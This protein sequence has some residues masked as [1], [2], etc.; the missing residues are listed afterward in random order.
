MSVRALQIDEHIMQLLADRA[1]EGLS[2]A[3]S[4]KLDAILVAN[5]AIHRDAM[6][7]AAASVDLAFDTGIVEPL[8]KTLR[9][10]I[11]ADAGGYLATAGAAFRD[12]S[13]GEPSSAVSY[14]QRKARI[15]GRVAWYLLAASLLLAAVGW[16]QVIDIRPAARGFE[17]DYASFV[18]ETLDVI[19]AP[20]AGKVEDLYGVTGDVVWSDQVQAGFMRFTGLPPNDPRRMQYQLWIVDQTRDRNP[21]DGGVFDVVAGDGEV[22]VPIDAKLRV[23]HPAAFALT[24]EKP[25]GVVVSAG[26]LVV[27][28]AVSG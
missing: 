22:I 16:W 8:P 2:A 7:L 11:L 23:D 14:G 5:P 28:A 26:P 3:K 17:R 10:R 9:D 18:A 27:V 13:T 20:W 1:T 25:G 12:A 15:G 6:D 21:V 19:K 4:S 24:R